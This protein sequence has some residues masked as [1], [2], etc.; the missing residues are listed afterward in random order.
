M[1]NESLE[2]FFQTP[3]REAKFTDPEEVHVA[4]RGLKHGKA[5]GPNGIP[6]RVLKHLPKRAVYLLVIIFN[7]VLCTH[8][9][10]PVWKHARVNSILKPGKP[11]SYRPINLLYT[12]VKLF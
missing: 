6:N 7:A 5:P 1:V 11:T 2:S 3:A 8:H 10:P 9:I 4:I 12:I